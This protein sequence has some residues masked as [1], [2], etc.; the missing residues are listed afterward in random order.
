M[1]THYTRVLVLLA[2]L[3]VFA[4]CDSA[5]VPSDLGSDTTVSF[6]SAS[7]EISEED[8]SVTFEIV[9]NDPGFAPFSVELVR[10]D[11]MSDA[12]VDAPES[13]TLDFP[14]S[15]TSGETRSFTID[16]EDDDFFAEGTE[17]IA[18]TLE[19]PSGASIGDV[20]TFTLTVEEND[21]IP[22]DQQNAQ[23]IENARAQSLGARV[24]VR[25]VV[26][27]RDGSNI[28]IQ[29]ES[30]D[31]GASGIVVRDGDLADAYEA[32]DIQPGDRIHAVGELGAFSGILQVSG[33]VDFYELEREVYETPAPQS[34]TVDDL[35]D[36]GG[37]LYESEL[38]TITD[39]TVDPDGAS[40]FE[41]GTNYDATDPSTSSSITLR[42]IDDSFYVGEPIPSSA[43]TYTGIVG[44][45]NFGFGGARDPDTGYQLQPI[46]EGD[47]E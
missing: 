45:F 20:P 6:T 34:V 41:D 27:R 43:V 36:G 16:I 15:I 22:A 40:E 5:S 33:G 13:M 21:E 12:E 44:Q 14:E 3:A 8:G 9:V 17:E 11:N 25:G 10:S 46:L 29:D 23:T 31:T 47:L 28:F 37:E 26:T 4:G 2:A 42:I 7:E 1:L 19:N 30:G 24:I 38:V 35:L 39:L 32:G 18:Y